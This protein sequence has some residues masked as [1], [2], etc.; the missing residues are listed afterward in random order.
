[1]A[2]PPCM[3]LAII[4]FGPIV[5]VLPILL[6]GNDTNECSYDGEG[7]REGHRGGRYVAVFATVPAPA[8][9]ASRCSPAA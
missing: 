6:Q 9:Y 5:I 1:M 7:S 3:L 4:S 2:L 8:L